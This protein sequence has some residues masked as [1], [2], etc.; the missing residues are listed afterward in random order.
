MKAQSWIALLSLLL[1]C[2]SQEEPPLDVDQGLTEVLE[3]VNPCPAEEAIRDYRDLDFFHIQSPGTIE[4]E[5]E[6]QVLE[7]ESEDPRHHILEWI[8]EEASLPP[9]VQLTLPEGRNLE[10]GS[11]HH[12]VLLSRSVARY[13]EAILILR[14]FEHPELAPTLI[15]LQGGA[16]ILTEPLLGQSSVDIRPLARCA[17]L[18]GVCYEGIIQQQLRVD[19]SQGATLLFGGEQGQLSRAG[20]L[21]DVQVAM[22]RVVEGRSQCEGGPEAWYEVFIQ[23]Q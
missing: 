4:L 3:P 8:P 1:A 19:L 2:E 23:V 18:P 17:P 20:Y 9:R 11:K 5:G 10:L 21:Y 12:G 16:E 6:L 14:P 15:A 7:S 22:A 13:N